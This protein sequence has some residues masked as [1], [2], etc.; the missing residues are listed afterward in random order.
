[1]RSQLQFALVVGESMSPTFNHG[2]VVIGRRRIAVVSRGDAVIFRVEPSDYGDRG[3]AGEQYSAWL[4][5]RVK[6]TVAVPGDRAP[7]SLPEVLRQQH[8]G[9]VPVGHIAVA[10]DNPHSE[11]SA[12][13]GYVGVERVESVVLG[14]LR[15]GR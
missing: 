15:K 9:R 3:S 6:R 10:G 8:G 7:T 2:D 12:Q 11:G 13:F 4:T 14:R 5:R 1:M